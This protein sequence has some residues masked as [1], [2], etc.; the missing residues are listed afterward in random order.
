MKSSKI[1]VAVLDVL[2]NGTETTAALI[3]AMTSGYSTS[4]RKLKRMQYGVH[5]S[6]L[7]WSDLYEERQK[8][9]ATLNHLKVQGFVSLGKRGKNSAWRITKRGKEKLNVLHERNLYSKESISYKTKDENT[10]KIIVYDIPSA[11]SRKRWWLRTAL[12]ELGFTML[13][14]SVWIGKKKL[15]EEFLKD[16]EKR[17]MLSYIHI[18]EVK[19]AGTLEKSV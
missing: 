1:I 7:R 9:Y 4:Y 10:F 8:F 16:L 15:P 13:Q 3:D 6:S 19:K 18:F 2:Q 12:N 17:K 5:H 14:K 11:E